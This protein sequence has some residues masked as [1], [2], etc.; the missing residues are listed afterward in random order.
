MMNEDGLEDRIDAHVHFFRTVPG[1][2]EMRFLAPR[3]RDATVSTILHEHKDYD[4]SKIHEIE[5]TLM[6]AELQVSP[7][8]VE[9]IYCAMNAKTSDEIN[10]LVALPIDGNV[11]TTTNEQTRILA[12]LFPKVIIPA[13]S[14]NPEK[15][16]SA[17]ELEQEIVRTM[18]ISEEFRPIVK[19]HPLIQRFNLRSIKDE[20][21][22]IL[23]EFRAVLYVH[24]GVFQSGPSKDVYGIPDKF[25]I[26]ASD[27]IALKQAIEKFQRI[28]FILAHMGTPDLAVNSFWQ[29]RDVVIGHF[30]HAV[31]L[32]RRFPNVYGDISGLMW[33]GREGTSEYNGKSMRGYDFR[34]RSEWAFDRLKGY[35]MDGEMKAKYD[36]TVTLKDKIVFGS[37]Y[38][39][40]DHPNRELRRQKQILGFN[41]ALN[42][43]AALRR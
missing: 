37:D 42:T 14:V 12:K 34:R 28:N 1:I 31:G 39:I 41:P 33:E 7:H 5:K 2:G 17:K 26:N 8:W 30:P 38:P 9:S 21:Y 18:K 4:S 23:A 29:D 35:T 16:N 19:I 20:F 40:T 15:E 10:R 22:S 25:D 3:F 24:T 11:S 32:M 27:P 43:K 6:D 36:R 13:V